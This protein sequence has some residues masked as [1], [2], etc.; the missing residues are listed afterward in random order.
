MG[1][2]CRKVKETCW[3]RLQ[4]YS[5]P[6]AWPRLWQCSALPLHAVINHR[7]KEPIHFRQGSITSIGTASTPRFIGLRPRGRAFGGAS[8][9]SPGDNS[10]YNLSQKFD[11][12]LRSPTTVTHFR[13][14]HPPVASSPPDTHRTHP[15]SSIEKRFALT[16]F[17][18]AVYIKKTDLSI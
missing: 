18:C 7:A 14:A 11:D 9:L 15:S 4:I 10:L 8:G 13:W 5:Q 16:P 2:R 6:C 1:I 17:S 3:R 12:E